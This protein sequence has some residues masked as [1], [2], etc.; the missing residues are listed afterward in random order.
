[1]IQTFN[2]VKIRIKIML[3]KNY[4]K[5]STL[6]NTITAVTNNL[7]YSTPLVIDKKEK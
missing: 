1:M 2:F 4:L 6:T 7:N 5:P 3:N